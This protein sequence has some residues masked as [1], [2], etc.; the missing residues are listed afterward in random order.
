LFWQWY[1]LLA[2]AVDDEVEAAV[3]AVRAQAELLKRPFER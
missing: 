1:P 2:A 3:M